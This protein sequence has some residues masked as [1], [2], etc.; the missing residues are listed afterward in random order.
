MYSFVVFLPLACSS[1]RF[2]FRPPSPG[3]MIQ[4]GDFRQDASGEFRQ[5]MQEENDS[6]L[7]DAH[8]DVGDD[9]GD[10]DGVQFVKK[11]SGD[12]RA[13]LT[14]SDCVSSIVGYFPQ[15][16]RGLYSLV[17]LLGVVIGAAVWFTFNSLTQEFGD[18]ACPECVR[19]YQRV[20][21]TALSI[22]VTG[23]NSTSVC[24]WL[25]NIWTCSGYCPNVDVGH[26]AHCDYLPRKPLPELVGYDLDCLPPTDRCPAYNV[27]DKDLQPPTLTPVVNIPDHLL[28]NFTLGARVAVSTHLFDYRGAAIDASATR[29]WTPEY[30]ESFRA[31]A[32]GRKKL[33]TY[34]TDALYPVLNTY[35]HI[36]IQGASVAVIG[37]E[38]PWVEASLLEWGAAKVTTIEYGDIV[39][40]VPEIVTITPSAFLRSIV[41]R[42]TRKETIERFDSIWTYSSLEHDG[43]GRYSDP[44]N[45]YG[46]LQS[47][48][49]LT[50]MLKPGGLLFLAF[51]VS[52]VDQLW[53]NVHRIYGP[54]RIPLVLR[55]YHLLQVF[56]DIAEG[57]SWANQPVLV[58]QN[59]IGCFNQ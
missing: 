30:I 1:L 3:I 21:S 8:T 41:D 54:I 11:Q 51:P 27:W 37:T 35:R 55:H 38:I 56:G 40:S 19:H 4:S 36:A 23:S 15:H 39:S 7:S 17:L 53:W 16:G 24:P 48:V 25:E 5:L 32:R 14:S 58:M 49:K 34:S 33:G 31:L 26:L 44:I 10:E 13:L 12:S 29:Y 59:R 47:L 45:P 42:Q 43:L 22:T 2:L 18:S 20:G 6:Q 50:C 9:A 46:D 28:S 57:N 52:R